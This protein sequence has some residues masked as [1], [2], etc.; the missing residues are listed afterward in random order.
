MNKLIPEFTARKGCMYCEPFGFLASL[1]HNE[2]EVQLSYILKR[3]L[4]KVDDY[5]R[6]W[7]SKT[8]A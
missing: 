1:G 6:L 7:A 2:L 5:K 4:L 3:F 8:S